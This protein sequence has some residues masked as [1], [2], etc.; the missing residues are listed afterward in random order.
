MNFRGSKPEV[1]PYIMYLT[2]NQPTKHVYL[3]ENLRNGVFKHVIRVF[4]CTVVELMKN[5]FS[6]RLLQ[7]CYHI[8]SL[9]T[10]HCDLTDFFPAESTK[11]LYTKND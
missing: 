4:R 1:M 2:L 8:G 11:K 5:A 6:V 3:R 7:K 9:L 10:S